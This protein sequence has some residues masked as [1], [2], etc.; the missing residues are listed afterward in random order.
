[1]PWTLDRALPLIRK[2]EALA[3]KYGAH[4]ALTGGVLYKDGERKD[5]DLLFYRI[6]QVKKIDEEGLIE[7]LKELGVFIGKRHGWVTKA[8]YDGQGIDM[9]FP[10]RGNSQEDAYSHA[11]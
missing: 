2:I 6:R 9:F 5:L 3:P 8:T 7:A 10:E 4:V 11:A 1:M